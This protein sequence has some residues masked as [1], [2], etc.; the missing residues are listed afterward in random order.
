MPSPSIRVLVV[1]DSV[2]ARSILT[3]ILQSA[4]DIQVVGEAKDGRSALELAQKLKP[5]L[6]TMDIYMPVMDGF[7]STKHIMA[8]C[9]TPILVVTASQNLRRD[10]D[11]VFESIAMGALD[12]VGKPRIDTLDAPGQSAAELLQKVR[13]LSRVKVVTHLAGRWP[14][15]SEIG[16]RVSE[17]AL[18]EGKPPSPLVARPPTP[19]TPLPALAAG[20]FEVVAIAAST[21]G[22]TALRQVLSALPANFPAAVAIV[23]HIAPGFTRGLVEWLHSFTNLQVQ[24]ATPTDWLRPGVALVA[25]SD[26]HLVVAPGGPIRLVDSEP[27]D[28]HRPSANVLFWSLAKSY[29]AKAI[30]VVLTGMGRDGAA[31]LLQMKQAGAVTLAQDEATSAVFG[32]PKAAI[33]FGAADEVLP[34]QEIG[35]RIVQLVASE[36]VQ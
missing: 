11:R 15:P 1:D 9:P 23:Q 34:I 17:A 10:R 29:G 25:P 30:G 36:T 35:P 19:A 13:L 21:G 22:P 16:A 2:S 3:L 8:Q 4:P 14:L 7:E 6:I 32:M 27:V 12:V 28:A 18:R 33:S 26:A 5:D 24:E 31:G 20:R